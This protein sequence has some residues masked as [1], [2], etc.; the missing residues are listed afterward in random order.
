V[1]ATFVLLA[2]LL[3]PAVLADRGGGGGQGGPSQVPGPGVQPEP[4]RSADQV[5]QQD[6]TQQQD[7]QCDDGPV[8]E[9]QHDGQDAAEGARGR[10]R[11]SS[12]GDGSIAQGN[13][14]AGQQSGKPAEPG[15]SQRPVTPPGQAVSSSVQ[16]RFA[17]EGE[18][19]ENVHRVRVQM[20]EPEDPQGTD[21]GDDI[22]HPQSLAQRIW[23]WQRALMNSAKRA[24]MTNNGTQPFMMVG[25]AEVDDNGA[26]TITVWKGNRLVRDHLHA[27]NASTI[28]VD[29]A[30]EIH[31]VDSSGVTVCDPAE[32][33]TC[34]ITWLEQHPD[35]YVSVWGRV[36]LDTEGNEVFIAYRVTVTVPDMGDDSSAA[37]SD[38]DQ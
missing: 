36:E 26:L 23:A 15:N 10:S 25:E 34:L 29:P 32:D 4:D 6:Q 12:A 13:A 11:A 31:L 16:S 14:P 27:D 33:P 17:S 19:S 18:T 22:D 37:E 8:Q 2:S 20:Q 35:A 3:G 30:G 9:R 21:N 24:P 1:A 38:Y 5:Q 28:T 7:Q